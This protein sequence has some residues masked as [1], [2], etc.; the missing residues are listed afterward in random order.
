MEL[1]TIGEAIVQFG[2]FGGLFIVLL[3]YTIKS[4]DKREKGYHNII[5]TL[6][7]EILDTAKQNRTCIDG[8]S[9]DV[10]DID[11]KLKCI[12]TKVDN[13]EKKVDEIVYKVDHVS[14]KI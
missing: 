10:D 1:T 2:I 9:K 4:N 7:T 13:V 6:N 14:S 5:S 11:A 3:I 12:E 8:L